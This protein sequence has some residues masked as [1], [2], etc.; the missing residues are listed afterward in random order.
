MNT[1]EPTCPLCGRP[2]EGGIIESHHLIPRS[3]KGTDT[4]DL[5]SVCHQKIHHT[6]AERELMTYYHTIDRLLES[7]QIQSFVKWIQKKEVGYYDKQKDTKER[8]RKRKR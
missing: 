8:K 3:F 7:E 1:N 4:V 2:L 5:H 6:F